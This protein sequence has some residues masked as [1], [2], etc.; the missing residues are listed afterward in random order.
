M[1]RS[2]E[3]NFNDSMHILRRDSGASIAYK[4]GTLVT[5]YAL[6][7]GIYSQK[8]AEKLI[9]SKLPLYIEEGVIPQY[10]DDFVNLYEASH[11]DFDG[12]EILKLKK[13]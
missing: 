3:R 1:K 8:Y 2:L 7:S 12:V 10:W 13:K 9:K 5:I 11:T 6:M 4:K